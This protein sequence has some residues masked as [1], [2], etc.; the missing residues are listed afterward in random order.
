MEGVAEIRPD[1]AKLGYPQRV[2]MLHGCKC[3]A[4]LK[5][6]SS[7]PLQMLTE[8]NLP[9]YSDP[10]TIRLNQ[11][12][13]VIVTKVLTHKKPILPPQVRV[14]SVQT[15]S[16]PC[17]VK[18]RVSLSDLKAKEMGRKAW[19]REDQKYWDIKSS[20]L[21]KIKEASSILR[22]KHCSVLCLCVKWINC[23]MQS[24]PWIQ[25][26]EKL[27]GHLNFWKPPCWELSVPERLMQ[28]AKEEKQWT[29]QSC[30]N[31]WMNHNTDQDGKILAKM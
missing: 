23:Q 19:L 25:D 7:S 1:F 9:P 24:T 2:H 26:L 29:D 13:S 20:A 15:P 6:Q 22:P 5:A 17:Y 3:L 30:C 28:A 10:T 11:S 4:A 12:R 18:Q 27:S 21:D 31:A 16:H 8:Q 14:F